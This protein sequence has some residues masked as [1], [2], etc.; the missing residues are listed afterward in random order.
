MSS[1]NEP[2]KG[3]EPPKATVPVMYPYIPPDIDDLS[4]H[5]QAPQSSNSSSNSPEVKEIPVVTRIYSDLES[6]YAEDPVSVYGVDNMPAAKMLDVPLV[7]NTWAAANEIKKEI[8][9]SVKESVSE[10]DCVHNVEVDD[11][12]DLN[13]NIETSTGPESSVAK[14]QAENCGC[15]DSTSCNETQDTGGAEVSVLVLSESHLILYILTCIFKKKVLHAVIKIWKKILVN[16]KQFFNFFVFFGGGGISLL[17]SRYYIFIP[18][19]K[20]IFRGWVGR[21]SQRSLNIFWFIVNKQP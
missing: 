3:I 16:C 4:Y 12:S 15:N 19:L 8:K 14:E 10:P 7:V 5:P 9:N 11:S 1:H 18:K 17:C 2:V 13:V 20:E 21:G 6:H